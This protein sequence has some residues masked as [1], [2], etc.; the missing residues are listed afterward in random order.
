MT[1][2]N[3]QQM[4]QDKDAASRLEKETGM[5]REMMEQF[6]QKHQR[7]NVPKAADRAGQELQT[8]PGANR[9]TGPDPNLPGFDPNNRFSTQTL[10][11]RGAVTQD[12]ARDNAEALRFAAP[13]EIRSGFEAYKSA[14]SRSRTLNP[15]GTPP[16]STPAPA[17]GAGKR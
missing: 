4:L 6:V 5:S 13:P 16:A 11:D 7:G 10:R 14:L 1:L 15:S 9:P 12:H 3:V 8:K 2:R 17:K